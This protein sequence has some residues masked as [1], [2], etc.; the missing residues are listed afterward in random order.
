MS[1]TRAEELAAFEAWF[2]AGQPEFGPTFELGWQAATERSAARIAE[3]EAQVKA[4]E[5]LGAARQQKVENGTELWLWRNG[6]HMLAFLHLYP[7]FRPGGDPMTLGEP[8][9]RAIFRESH[10]RAAPTTQG[11]DK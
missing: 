2:R 4:L 7:C 5:V 11:A 9:G 3:L 6:D 8:F 10:D 1:D